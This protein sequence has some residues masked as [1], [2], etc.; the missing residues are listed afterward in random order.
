MLTRS[1]SLKLG[2]Q[3]AFNDL[4][5]SIT[6]EFTLENARPL[7]MQEIMAKYNTGY[8]RSID[9]QKTYYETSQV[10]TEE[11]VSSTEEWGYIPG[12]SVNYATASKSTPGDVNPANNNQANS[13]PPGNTKTNADGSVSPISSSESETKSFNQGGGGDTNNATNKDA[14]SES[15]AA[16]GPTVAPIARAGF[17]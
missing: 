11:G 14:N 7:G 8:L 6:A 15:P 5:S 16:S 9:V 12:E 4:P 17:L 2:P 3:L 10:T 1:V 13:L